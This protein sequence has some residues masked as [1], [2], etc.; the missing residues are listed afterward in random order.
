MRWE[1]NGDAPVRRT[2]GNGGQQLHIQTTAAAIDRKPCRASGGDRSPASIST[3]PGVIVRL[4]KLDTSPAPLNRVHSPRNS[5]CSKG[6]AA[7]GAQLD[8][9]R[10]TVRFGFSTSPSAKAL[11]ENDTG[12][13]VKC[14]VCHR[15]MDHW[16]QA[17]RNQVIE[18]M[19]LGS[20]YLC[21]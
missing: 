15:G 10:A 14:P 18:R 1:E 21:C 17:Q 11:E 19:L 4:P 8:N 20:Y 5:T 6:G 12:D 9:V 2:Q 3:S 13:K 16:P 7:A